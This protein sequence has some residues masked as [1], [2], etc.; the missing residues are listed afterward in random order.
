MSLTSNA[1][2]SFPLTS[3]LKLEKHFGRMCVSQPFMSNFRQ[4]EKNVSKKVNYF[5]SVLT[6]LS[7]ILFSIFY[8]K[9]TY[10]FESVTSQQI[11]LI[12]LT[13]KHY[14]KDILQQNWPLTVHFNH[15]KKKIKKIRPIVKPSAPISQKNIYWIEDTL[16]LL[17]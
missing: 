4:G 9:N 2:A 17:M 10:H 12:Q 11:K 16:G 15:Q 1:F 14:T 7:M 8:N 3:I 5:K 13:L 6:V